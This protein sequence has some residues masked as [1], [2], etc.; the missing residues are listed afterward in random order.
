MTTPNPYAPPQSEVADPSPLEAA[1]PLWNPNAAASWSVLL[2]P[3]FGAWLHMKNWQAMGETQKAAASRQWLWMSVAF[4][5]LMVLLSVALPENDALGALSRFGGIGLLV[6]WYFSLGKS[7]NAVVLAR[8][9]KGYP[10]KGWLKPLGWALLAWLGFMFAAVL[11][12]IVA[13]VMAG[14]T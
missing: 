10:R 8:Y 3:I 5:V 13:G 12:G 11:V 6:A 1:P 7:Q 9:G 2:S 4:L 14:S